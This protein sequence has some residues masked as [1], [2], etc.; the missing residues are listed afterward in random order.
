MLISIPSTLQCV[1]FPVQV[2]REHYLRDDI[3]SGSPLDPESDSASNKLSA[4]AKHY[5][6]VDTNVALSQ[7]TSLHGMHAVEGP[8]H[9][10]N[11]HHLCSLQHKLC[12][13]RLHASRKSAAKASPLPLKWLARSWLTVLAWECSPVALV[14]QIDFLEHAAVD[15]VIVMSVVLE[16]VRHRNS[17]VYQRLRRL[18]ESPS[19]RF[20][21]FVN[22]HHRCVAPAR[23]THLSP[24]P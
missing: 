18:A 8:S 6:V 5:L 11:R 1:H 24:A 15:D 3:W 2:S 12:L 9:V 10:A 23:A 21:V 4:T 13:T 7:V 22:E 19:K 20:F 17:S 16:E 14:V